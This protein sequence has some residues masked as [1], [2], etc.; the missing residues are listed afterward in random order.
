MTKQMNCHQI[1][2]QIRAS[3]GAWGFVVN[4]NLLSIQ[5][6]LSTVRALGLLLTNDS[7]GGFWEVL[8]LL[9][10]LQNIINFGT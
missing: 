8:N 10:L 3:L 4:M 2:H 9:R 7:L 1:G 5:E 6:G